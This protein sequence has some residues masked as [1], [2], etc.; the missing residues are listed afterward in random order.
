MLLFLNLWTNMF[1]RSRISRSRCRGSKC[2]LRSVLVLAALCLSVA[3]I[4]SAQVT[5]VNVTTRQNDI[6]RTGQNLD[7][8]ILTTSNVNATQFGKIFSQPVAGSVNA[9]PLYLSNI[10]IRGAA[11]NVVYVATRSDWV[12]AF[13]A[14]SNAGKNAN[15]LWRVSLLDAAHGASSGAMNFGALGVTSTPVIDPTSLT[16][17]IVSV[18][19]E[20][21]QAIYR[22]HALDVTSGAEKFNGPTTIRGSVAGSALD[23]VGGIVTFIPNF[24]KQNASLLLLNGVVYIGFGS[25]TEADQ[26]YW[27]GW[28]FA[29]AADTL[30][31]TGVFCTTPNGNRGGVWMFGSGLAADQLDPVNSPFG[32]MFV[33][34]GNGDFTGVLPYRSN[35]DFGDSVVNLDLTNGAPTP[36]DDFTPSDQAY[37]LSRDGDQGSGGVMILPT[38]TTGAY[39]NLLVQAGKSGTLY[40]LDRNNLGGYSPTTDQ[41]VQALP[42]AVGKTGPLAATGVWSAPAY[43]NGNVYYWG[44]YDYLKSFPLVNGLLSAMP[45]ASTE[46]G[47]YPGVTPSISANG[48]AQGIVWAVNVAGSSTVLMA[49]DAG[50]VATTLYSSA[51]NAARDGAGLP[52]PHAVPTIANGHVYLATTNLLNV[53]GLLSGSQTIAPIISPSSTKFVG[54]VGATITD[55]SPNATIYYTTD[56]TPATTASTPYSGP[57]SVTSS[58]TINAVAS[59]PGLTLSYQ[60]WTSY[61][62][63]VTSPPTFSPPAVA[64]SSAQSVTIS[65]ATPG[66]TIYYTTN[67]TTPTIASSVYSGPIN[68]SASETLNAIAVAPGYAISSVGSISYV[69]SNSSTILVNE[70]AGFASASGLSFVGP[71]KLVNNALQL[72]AVGKGA[73]DAAAWYSTPVNVQTFTTDF[74]FQETTATGD[75]FT[76][77]LQNA[78]A[79]LNAVGSIAGGGLGYKGIGS[80]VAVK[81]DL[82]DDAGE[83]I[84]STGFYTDGAAPTVP[85]VDM[86]ASGINLHGPDILHAHINYDGTTLTL[87]LIDTVTSASFT[88]STAI[89]IPGVV[90]GNWA[91]A[92]FTASSTG[93]NATATQTILNWTYVSNSTTPPLTAT[94]TFAPVAGKYPTAQSVTIS[95]ATAGATIHYTTD[96]TTP[97][98]S[99]AVY[100]SPISVSA[101]ETLKAIAVANNYSQSLLAVATYGIGN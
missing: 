26:A 36:T 70:A 33:A 61:T 86:S 45:T 82:Y 31:Q 17:Y 72:T 65:D 43:W 75:G 22:L 68:V 16:M 35:M 13:D 18:S 50:N 38:Q 80:S 92:G 7:E 91:Y 41:V 76:F 60:S 49:H 24:E 93:S 52:N 29:Y 84:D 78:P 88:T 9:Q 3:P 40:L 69:I 48:S 44:V 81:F 37:L 57:I 56:G 89:N 96:G 90:G 87:T 79:G 34:T 47:G 63:T 8:T 6:G 15:P 39:P 14:G 77:T 62:Q 98:I 101:D 73:Q 97:T 66:A 20:G 21:G 12:Y 30:A 4:A 5:Q 1:P 94:P 74:Y 85:A 42:L 51:T 10:M 2:A 58:Q 55:A 100:S 95:D 27:H 23:G 64:Y 99:S 53:Y 11:H 59:A 67:G 46:Q 54:S 71:T 19:F 28:I 32:R 25:R 83:G